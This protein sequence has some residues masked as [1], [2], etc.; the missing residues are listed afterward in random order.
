[1]YFFGTVK[2]LYGQKLREEVE[3]LI[4]DVGLSEKK[5]VPSSS[6]SGG[7]KRKLQLAMALIGGSKFV[8]LD[9]PTS[10]MV[11]RLPPTPVTPH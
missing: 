4:D 3:Q 7:M 5:H 10:G 8:L 1:M 2:G 11:P 6:L 9:E